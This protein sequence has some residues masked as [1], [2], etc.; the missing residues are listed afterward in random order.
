MAG[1][2]VNPVVHPPVV[3][4]PAEAPKPPTEVPKPEGTQTATTSPNWQR[5]LFLSAAGVW[6]LSIVLINFFAD[7]ISQDLTIAASLGLIALLTFAAFYSATGTEGM[8]TAIAATLVVFYL[9]LVT[10]TVAS[11]NFRADLEGPAPTPRAQAS[12][13]PSRTPT[14]GETTDAPVAAAEVTFGRSIFNNLTEFVKIVLLFYFGA[15]TAEK[16]ANTAAAATNN[17]TT[18]KAE[19]QKDT[20]EKQVEASANEAEAAKARLATAS[21]EL[22][23]VR[24]Q[25]ENLRNAGP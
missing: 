22:E 3:Q 14:T 15:V 19:A 4:P 18:V 12:P 10:H 16:L 23:T 20:A 6:V 9:V 2:P 13:G 25:A 5:R 11:P 1:E 17:N 8:R 21:A 24:V 7:T